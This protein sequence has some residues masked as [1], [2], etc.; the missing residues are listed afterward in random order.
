[1]MQDQSDKDNGKITLP[2]KWNDEEGEFD[3][4]DP[5]DFEKAKQLVN[6]GYGYQKGQEKLKIVE[7][8]LQKAQGDLSYWNELI[9]EAEKTGD[10]S[11]V[12]AALE[13]SGLKWDK[14]DDD[15]TL[16]EGDKATKEL[17]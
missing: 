5:N 13:M 4:S 6:K 8:E 10:N 15:V 9:L 2:Y 1:M 17:T 7:G 12:T 3:L 11:K 16:D 14:T